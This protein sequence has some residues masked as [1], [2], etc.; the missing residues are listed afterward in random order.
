MPGWIE[1]FIALLT[2]HLIGD[3]VLQND[4]M[5]RKKHLVAVLLFHALIVMGLSALLLGFPITPWAFAI[6]FASYLII[7]LIKARLL[8]D[9][10]SSFI[11]DQLFHVT[12]LLA[13]SIWFS[14]LMNQGYWSRLM[15]ESLMSVYLKGLAGVSGFITCVLTGGVLIGKIVQMWSEDI[16]ETKGLE[17]GGRYIGYLERAII[18]L[19]ILMGET[20]VIGFLFA[21][22]SILRFGEIR[23][24]GQRK[25][26]EYVIIG[27]FMSFGW[28][29]LVSV[30]TKNALHYW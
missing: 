19:L 12:V 25:L 1:T 20:A 28:S 30:L 11:L 26:A 22:K 24:P 16:N 17:N 13:V 2:G 14:Q 15:S 9:N 18:F 3:F 27:T 4:W 7:D 6:L 23:D 21:A 5:S 29:M 8:P 10:H